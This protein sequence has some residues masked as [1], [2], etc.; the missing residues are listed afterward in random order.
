MFIFC[1]KYA[2]WHTWF[3]Y[4][5]IYFL[6]RG[7]SQEITQKST[8]SKMHNLG[9]KGEYDYIYIILK[10]MFW[11]YCWHRSIGHECKTVHDFCFPIWVPAIDVHASSGPVLHHWWC[12][13]CLKQMKEGMALH[14]QSLCS[15]LPSLIRTAQVLCF[16]WHHL[17]SGALANKLSLL[18]G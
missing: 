5:F 4:F 8:S 17:M 10:N 14:P 3:I 16:Y 2:V 6:T 18:S 1:I 13:L 15:Q 11:F 9:L 12:S 7:Q